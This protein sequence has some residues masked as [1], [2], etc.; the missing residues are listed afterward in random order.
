[1]TTK[2]QTSALRQQITILSL[3]I[4]GFF[5]F[6]FL[7]PQHYHTSKQ[8]FYSS[9][10]LLF[11][12]LDSTLTALFF[13]LSLRAKKIWKLTFIFFS[14]ASLFRV[15]LSLS[16]SVLFNT[17]S[18]YLHIIRTFSIT[19]ELIAWLLF[20]SQLLIL[21]K[22]EIRKFTPFIPT[23]LT[24]IAAIIFLLHNVHHYIARENVPSWVIFK[25]CDDLFSFMLIIFCLP[26]MKKIPLVILATGFLLL[27]IVDIFRPNINYTTPYLFTS[28]YAHFFLLFAKLIVTYGVYLLIKEQKLRPKKWFY[29]IDCTRTQIIYWGNSVAAVLFLLIGIHS[30]F[31]EKTFKFTS[32]IFHINVHLL[33][34]VISLLLLLTELF[35]RTFSHCYLQIQRNISRQKKSTII[36]FKEL[37]QFSNITVNI[38]NDIAK[39]NEVQKKMFTVSGQ[40]AH[41]IRTPL[42]VLDV[43]CKQAKTILTES[44]W[45]LYNNALVQIRATTNELLALQQ[46]SSLDKTVKQSSQSQYIAIL[47]EQF[48]QE[49]AIQYQHLNISIGIKISTP[50]WFTLTDIP[51]HHFYRILVDL[52]NNAIEESKNSAN[53]FILCKM[54]YQPGENYFTVTVKNSSTTH[55]ANQENFQYIKRKITEWHTSIKISPILDDNREVALTLPTTN[56]LPNWWIN[57][58]TLPSKGHIIIF[59]DDPLNHQQWEEK[60]SQALKMLPDVSLTHCYNEK[61][62]IQATKAK[63]EKLFLIDYDIKGSPQLGIDYIIQFKLQKQ[64]ILVTNNYCQNDLQS[65]CKLDHISLL[66]KPII[67]YIKIKQ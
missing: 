57:E 50:A 46:K 21:Y 3:I 27:I 56:P 40:A 66:P 16:I 7:P 23:A 11:I 31:A 58:I 60:L 26:M 6:V 13:M 17:D 29:E 61:E 64:A 51:P 35:A 65:Q 22:K 5:I 1:M 63:E 9:N 38:M 24:L 47:F 18:T 19:L 41:D 52:I 33:V 36:Y 2:K 42:S 30:L 59:D 62:F 43:L 37:R 53:K 67:P 8:M 25:A 20:S 12:L 44:E 34:P 55:K 54:D 39:K 45:L 15:V 49:K 28:H 48:I 10:Q 32:F 14:T 4:I